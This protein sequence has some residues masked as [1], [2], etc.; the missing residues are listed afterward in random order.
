MLKLKSKELREQR[1]KLIA[2]SREAL[3]GKELT[4][5]VRTKLDKMNA[6]IDQITADITLYE[7]QENRERELATEQR[8][9]V[10]GTDATVEVEARKAEKA[11]HEKR[12]A[13]VFFKYLATGTENLS[14]EERS[15]LRQGMIAENRAQTVT[16]TGGGYAIPQGFMGEVEKA[17]KYFLGVT[18]Y[19][20]IMNTSGGNPLPWP[21]VDDTA[22][23]GED[24]AIN[25]AAGAQDVVFGQKTLGAYKIGSGM[26]TVPTELFEDES[27]NLNSILAE[28]M[29][30]R[31][32]RRR[33]LKYTTGVGTTDFTGVVVGASDS[34]LTFAGVAAITTDELIT[35]Q[36]KVDKAY[37]NN[38]GC[39][40]QMND[41]TVRYVRQL[42]DGQS[43]YILDPALQA[44][45]I[46]KLLGKP[47]I[48]NN[49]MATLATGNKTVVFG[50]H[51]KFAI[52]NVRN[53]IV[54]RLDERF[55]DADQVGFVAWYRGDSQVVSAST[56]ALV[57]AKQA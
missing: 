11:A 54:R 18:P 24:K 28:I 46:D 38:P 44:D 39:I 33:S 25:T 7:K 26:I 13:D 40:W 5:E 31:L 20:R 19:A 14:P 22:N 15:I 41:D 47:L 8:A 1:A 29:G 21:T 3:N 57:Y 32:G 34:G 12:Y 27:V 6:D 49:D 17:Q 53:I 36:H 51:G 4:A 35:L 56:K 23:S 45:G 10:P 37:R 55:A 52:R 16:T 48:S 30:E 2:D 43:R 42:K 9:I 50:D